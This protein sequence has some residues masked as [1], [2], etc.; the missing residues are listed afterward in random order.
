MTTLMSILKNPRVV[1]TTIRSGSAVSC[2]Y[3][4]LWRPARARRGGVPLLE[5]SLAL[6]CGGEGGRGVINALEGGLQHHHQGG[7]Q[8]LGHRAKS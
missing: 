2:I 6:V 3:S 7:G 1:I 4:V 5:R 8:Y